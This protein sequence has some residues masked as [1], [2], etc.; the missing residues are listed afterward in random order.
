VRVECARTPS[1]NT[2]MKVTEEVGGKRALHDGEDYD[3][4]VLKRFVMK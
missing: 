3:V 4:L 1:S 2:P